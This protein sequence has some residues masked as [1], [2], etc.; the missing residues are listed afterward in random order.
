[1]PSITARSI[2][3][4][5]LRLLGVA[6]AGQPIA[7]VMAQDAQGALNTLID[8]WATERLLTYARPR[9]TLD[10]VPGQHVYTWGVDGATGGDI[11]VEAP[12]RL[13][14]CLLT[15]PGSLPQEWELAILSQADYETGIWQKTLASSY[16]EC[17]YLEPTRPYARLHVWPVPTMAYQLQLIPWPGLPPYPTLDHAVDW[18]QGYERAFQYNLAIDLAPEYTLEPS[19]TVQRL[20]AESKRAL[21][22]INARPGRLRMVPGV[23]VST[24]HLVRFLN[25]G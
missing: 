17:V 23:P 14:I 24:S 3:E 8:A 6:S 5:A 18:P 7:A 19:P 2:V 13:E 10:L 11:P 16:P 9:L 25:G 15:V 21:Y 22:P 4:R 12:L 20:A 1:M